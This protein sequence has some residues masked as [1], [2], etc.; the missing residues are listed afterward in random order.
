M[1]DCWVVRENDDR[2]FCLNPRDFWQGL[3][4]P[5]CSSPHSPASIIQTL[6]VPWPKGSWSIVFIQFTVQ[7]LIHQRC[8]LIGYEPKLS[9]LCITWSSSSLPLL[10]SL[11]PSCS[12]TPPFCR[13]PFWSDFACAI[14]TQKPNTENVKA[15]P[16]QTNNNQ[17]TTPTHDGRVAS[18]SQPRR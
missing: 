11:L 3:F 14:P 6:F 12:P 9:I 15:K 13:S 17:A 7:L 16:N 4:P 18:Q 5:R 2:A 10:S 1:R 8:T